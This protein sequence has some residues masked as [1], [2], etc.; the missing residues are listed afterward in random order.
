MIPR[1]IHYCWFG[2]NPLPKDV[3]KCIESWKKY[4]PEY[5]I[6]EWN[7]SNFDVNSHPFTKAAYEAKSW[8]FVADY[9]RLKVVY[10]NGGMYFDTDVEL[11]KNPDFLL[12]NKCYIGVQQGAHLCT[13][14]LGFGAV[15]FSPI[16][17]KMMNKYD[18]LEFAIESKEKFA[19]PYLNNSVLAELGYQYSE[20]IWRHPLVTVY[21]CTFFDPIAPGD[22]QYLLG[23]DTVSIHHYAASWT[24]KTNQLKRKLF[25]FIGNENIY[26]LKKVLKR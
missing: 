14:G 15:K 22:S 25:R 20:K 12:Q 4:A 26:K 3:K 11:L 1:I 21:P 10:D 24:G 8:A 23:P 7:E 18:T 2:E 13:T 6:I 9:A 17:Q 16:V 5:E 19:C